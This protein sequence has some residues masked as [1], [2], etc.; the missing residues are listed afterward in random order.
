MKKIKFLLQFTIV[1][2]SFWMLY[3]ILG[4]YINPRNQL[5]QL[6][7]KKYQLSQEQYSVFIMGNSHAYR[8]IQPLV[9][10]ELSENKSFLNLTTPGT[11]FFPLYEY[12]K[13]AIKEGQKPEIVLVEVTT[14]RMKNQANNILEIMDEYYLSRAFDMIRLIP[15]KDHKI[16]FSFIPTGFDWMNLLNYIQRNIEYY[17]SLE[18]IDNFTFVKS[19]GYW[20]QDHE[21]DKEMY[22]KIVSTGDYPIDINYFNKLFPAFVSLCKENDIQLILFHSPA[23]YIIGNED[24]YAEEFAK[25][26]GIPYIDLNKNIEAEIEFPHLLFDDAFLG[27]NEPSSSHTNDTGSLYAS[28]KLA[29]ELE[30]SGLIKIN[31]NAYDLYWNQMIYRLQNSKEGK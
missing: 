5:S 1:C 11:W 26:Y 10:D 21:L 29:K 30:K 16:A 9:L 24:A 6:E 20:Y 7:V 31:Q 12:L 14:L 23:V 25:Y 2:F 27:I 17:Q 8:S 28:L 18:N 3:L 4:R 22:Q 13:M 15:E 19:K